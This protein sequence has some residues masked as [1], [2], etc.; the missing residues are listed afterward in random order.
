MAGLH[1]A[2]RVMELG[3]DLGCAGLAT[4]AIIAQSDWDAWL[5]RADLQQE[6]K[7]Q[8]ETRL[9]MGG[10]R[11]D[12]DV[13]DSDSTNLVSSYQELE[14]Y[15]TSEFEIQIEWGKEFDDLRS[16]R[17]Q[18][19]KLHRA[20]TYIVNYLAK[21]VYGDKDRALDAFKE[22]FGQ[23]EKHGQ[24]VVQLGADKYFVENFSILETDAGYYGFVPL[25]PPEAESTEGG[26][27]NWDMMFLGSNVDIATIVHEFGHVI[28][29]SLNIVDEYNAAAKKGI[30]LP[31]WKKFYDD[32][33]L[34]L[35]DSILQ[36]GIEGFAGKQNANEEFWADLFMTAVLDSVV[37]GPLTVYSSTYER[38]ENL[39]PT[40]FDR[41]LGEGACSRQ[42]VEWTDQ[43]PNAYLDFGALA[44]E[45][46]PTLL[47]KLLNG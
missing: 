37:G 41:C 28:D 17:T 35:T 22:H 30:L 4:L 8:A 39:S 29:R 6:S 10:G 42:P 36:Y 18:L 23:S 46:F 31:A 5:E 19:H 13:D 27:D 21:E 25:P 1:V 16:R 14:A 12:T 11:G 44:Q 33:G 20:I 43:S 26:D 2:V 32:T 34:L 47:R 38:I 15:V 40:Q 7:R 9:G 45:H 24:L 3:R